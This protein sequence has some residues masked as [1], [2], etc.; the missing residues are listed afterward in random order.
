MSDK[1]PEKFRGK[2][3]ARSFFSIDEKIERH[4]KEEK[5]EEEVANMWRR[6]DD[7]KGRLILE[8][9]EGKRKK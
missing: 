2:L 7:E 8:R 5:E 9:E 6:M 1:F 3:G 4:K